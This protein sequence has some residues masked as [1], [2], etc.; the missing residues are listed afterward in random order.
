MPPLR[1][2]LFQ[3]FVSA[4][5]SC[6]ARITLGQLMHQ[7]RVLRDTMMSAAVRSGVRAHFHESTA[8]G[9]CVGGKSTKSALGFPIVAG[10]YRV[11]CFWNGWKSHGSM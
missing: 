1:D 5:G 3:W 11:Q 10:K 6:A 4:R 9:C 7:A 2:E 8:T